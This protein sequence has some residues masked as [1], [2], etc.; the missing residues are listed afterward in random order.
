[1][2][3]PEE[4]AADEAKVWEL[5]ETEG[6]GPAYAWSEMCSL[7]PTP[8]A[9]AWLE[10]ARADGDAE[11]VENFE[12]LLSVPK[13]A[14]INRSPNMSWNL[15]LKKS[16]AMATLQRLATAGMDPLADDIKAIKDRAQ[17]DAKAAFKKIITNPANERVL[18]DQYHQSDKS[19]GLDRAS[20]LFKTIS[21][22]RDENMALSKPQ[23]DS[24]LNKYQ[25]ESD[26]AA[27]T[28]AY[29]KSFEDT[30][31]DECVK[32]W[33]EQKNLAREVGMAPPIQEETPMLPPTP[34]EKPGAAAAQVKK[35]SLIK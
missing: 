5:L 16:A 24:I 21:T 30:M 3:T 19:Q 33:Q 13:S 1:M 35:P 27:L 31:Y 2:S 9:K 6:W 22:Q 4:Q 12:R 23:L 26:K 28:G 11:T 8:F 25:E 20:E 29:P 15:D 18:A 14:A 7:D 34:V 17:D 32:T 10:Q